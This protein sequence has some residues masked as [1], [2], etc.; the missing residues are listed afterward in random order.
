MALTITLFIL[1]FLGISVVV[2]LSSP[3]FGKKPKGESLARLQASPNFVG[4]RFVNQSSRLTKE[5][6]KQDSEKNF[7][8]QF[9]R[10]FIRN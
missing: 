2:F 7:I 10:F 9:W 3:R 8:R 1:A 4:G 5:Q 6:K